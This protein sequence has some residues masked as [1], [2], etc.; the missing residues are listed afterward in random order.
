MLVVVD[1]DRWDGSAPG[2]A[3]RADGFPAWGAGL[4][5]ADRSVTVLVGVA[6]APRVPAVPLDVFDVVLTDATA[7]PSGAP[8]PLVAVDDVDAALDQLE[9]ATARCPVAAAVAA[10]VLRRMPSPSVADDLLV[11][12][13]AYASLQAGTEHRRW[14]AGTPRPPYR[15]SAGPPVRLART[16]EQ[17]TVVLDRPE[18][19]NAVDAATRDGLCEAF[20]LVA[21]DPTIT[22]VRLRGSGPAFSSGGDL[23]EFGTG[24]DPASCHLLRQ[25]RPAARLLAAVAD[26]VTAEVHGVCVGAGL[27]L[28]AAAGTVVADPAARFRLPELAMGLLPGA[29]GT[30]TVPRRIGR[31]RTAW[32]VLSGRWLPADTA[33]A[34]GL[35]DEVRP[36][37]PA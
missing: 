25:Q 35:V 24:P 18:V 37:G 3:S 16:G 31:H 33:L 14:L 20:E 27:E 5:D 17:L 22:D 11:E 21:A 12:S 34:W 19:R 9:R 8:A 10:Q 4:G 2:A 23:G 32:L 1:V 30:A 29:G 28:A 36:V 7:W 26:R 15:P 6:A 13:L